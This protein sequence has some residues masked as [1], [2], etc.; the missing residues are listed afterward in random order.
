MGQSVCICSRGI[1][2]IENKRYFFI[3]NLDEGG[4]SYVDLVEGA[5]NG[6]FYALKRIICHD[7]EDRK[8]ALHEVEMHRMFS[9][10]NVLLLEAHCIQDK[11]PKCEAWLLL[12][13][14]RKGSLWAELEKLRDANSF[15]SE[16]RILRI[17]HGIC[18]GL[19]AI[20]D[21]G[22]AHRD[23]KPTN[24]L[25]DED[26][27]PLLMD[28]GSM[29]KARIEVK[30][31][32]EAMSIQDWAAQR[33]TISYRAPELFTV[34]SHCIID[35]RTD[36]WSLGCVLYAM[37]FLEGPYD[38]IFHKGDSVALAV[39][40]PIS[41]PINCRMNLCLFL[42]EDCLGASCNCNTMKKKAVHAFDNLQHLL[43]SM[44]VVNPQE[45]PN[46]SWVLSQSEQLQPPGNIQETS[47]I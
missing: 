8:N 46:I 20:H 5:Q 12:P 40:N 31:S 14:I 25:L 22:Y 35:E 10:P 44:M 47:R 39:Q 9:H 17:F 2:T 6:R 27:Q 45:R 15:M 42:G 32:R 7:K 16:E 24:V 13:Y 41:I 4:F 36:I 11:S 34:E 3:Q 43:R 18:A 23:V 19:K 26:E 21:K 30:G 33:C 29:N 1:L 28:L 38:G 37:M